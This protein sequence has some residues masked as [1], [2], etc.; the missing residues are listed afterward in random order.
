MVVDL[1]AVGPRVCRGSGREYI[2]KEKRTV[3]K[4]N[5]QRP[6]DSLRVGSLKDCEGL[7]KR[8]RRL[9]LKGRK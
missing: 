7:G 9:V 5:G 6:V 1:G 4:G 8:L 3:G 2:R